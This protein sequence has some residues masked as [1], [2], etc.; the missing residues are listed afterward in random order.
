MSMDS[1]TN[2]SPIEI[3]LDYPRNVQWSEQRWCWHWECAMRKA[4]KHLTGRLPQDCVKD[5]RMD[6]GKRCLCR[7]R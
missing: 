3:T 7:G 2:T 4:L 1:Q 5:W 6:C